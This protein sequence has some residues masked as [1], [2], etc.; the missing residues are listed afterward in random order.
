[1]AT[2]TIDASPK[3]RTQSELDGLGRWERSA[4]LWSGI[5]LFTFVLTHLLNHALGIFGVSVMEQVQPWRVAIWRSVPGTVLLYGAG[6]IHLLFV[7]K[8]IVGRRT[9]RMPL[10]EALQIALGLAIPFLLYQHAI[11]TRY[12]SEFA[13]VNDAYAVTLQHLWP[14]RL[15]IQLALIA[16]VWTHGVIGINYSMRLQPW[17]PR[18]RE[19]F[20]IVSVIIPIL[21]AAGYIAG[22]REA[23]QL[24]H[25]DARWSGNQVMVYS[26]AARFTYWLLLGAAATLT[27]WLAALA[28]YRRFGH[29]VPV[30]YLGHGSVYLPR[31]STLL[32]ASRSNKIPHPSVCG[33]RAR[34]STCRVLVLEGGD[35]LPPP[36]P[37]EAALLQRIS[38]PSRVRLACQI[39]PTAPILVQILLPVTAN[40]NGISDWADDGAHETGTERIATVLFIDLRGFT[41]LTKTQF[42]Y[43]LIALLNRYMSEI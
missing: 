2:P 14:N 42:P 17:Y 13:A 40:G 29:R 23:V 8:R 43:D 11:G 1:M 15:W 5:V 20:L 22:G 7:I 37:N 9:W 28:L 39:R 41:E 4:R 27:A 6:I 16:V 38:A 31:G 35:T 30:R 26:D 12:V 19:P 25:A 33:G 18:V 36:S 32:E 21:A 10:R 24:A 34:C 3:V